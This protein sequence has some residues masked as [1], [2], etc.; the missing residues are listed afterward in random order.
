MG[1]Q[2]RLVDRVK[3]EVLAHKQ[4]QDQYPHTITLITDL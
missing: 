4:N 1:K 3:K 2:E